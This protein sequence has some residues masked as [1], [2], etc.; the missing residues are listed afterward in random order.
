[1]LEEALRARNQGS[2]DG[3]YAKNSRSKKRKAIRTDLW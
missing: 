2:G 3:N 1:M